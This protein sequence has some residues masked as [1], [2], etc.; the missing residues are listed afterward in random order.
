MATLAESFLADLDDL[1]DASV[2]ER[3]DAEP[4]Q[5]EDAEMDEGND[6]IEA[7]NYDDLEAVAR[8]QS[9]DRYKTIMQQVRQALERG[10]EVDDSDA[11]WTGP[12][13]EGPT[14]RLLV[15]CNQLAV[16]IDNEIAV[17]H[18]FMRDKYRPKFPE[19]ESL[20][21][22][23][24]DYARVVQKIGNEMDMTLIDLEDILPQATVMVVS[25]TASTTSGKQLSEENL[26][27]VLGAADMALQLDA[28]KA[29]ILRLV[30]LKMHHIAPNLS[31]AV[32]TEIAAKLMGVAGGLT[33]LSKMPACNVQ[34]LG[35]KRKHL[36]GFSS[37]TQALHQG[38]VYGCEIIQQTPPALRAKA[39]RM[40]G[41]KC[42]LLARVD[43]YGQDPTG[44]AG[45]AMKEEMQKKV[46][47]WQ[48]PPQAKQTRV[49]PVPDM[50]PKKRRGG[51]RARK[52]KERYG[53]TDVRKAANR[54]NFNQPEEEFLDGDD[55]VGLG[56]LGKEGSG[57]LRA[58]ARTQKQKLS[59]KVAKKYA[60][61]IG[62]SGGAT[63]GLS[64]TVAFTPLQGMELVNPVQAKD[65]D[66][67][68]GTESYF[69]EYSGF[70]SIKKVPGL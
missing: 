68:S 34:V 31:A 55:V 11:A 18:N 17:V 16:D 66:L 24:M 44:S 9:S 35:A 38:F 52:Y 67:R 51:R 28:D 50:E 61:K 23:P 30:Q 33:S 70:R 53:L 12:S 22:H 43:A 13:E 8:L 25:V 6:D 15:D 21:H 40:V 41:A 26:R 10:G 19:L 56:V 39:A 64:S 45:A 46:A 54:V 47:K 59:A 14:Y 27:R 49:L 57:Q 36:S 29:D 63:N 62:G 69:S 42:T 60:K 4:E 65:D 32:G 2:D 7:L 20:V 3:E 37:A 48:E 5:D 1:S 58:Q